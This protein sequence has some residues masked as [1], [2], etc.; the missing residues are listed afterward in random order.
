MHQ[1]KPKVPTF[2]HVPKN[3]GTYYISMMML[4]FR[5]WRR[6]YRKK[7]MEMQPTLEDGSKKESIKN[8]EMNKEIIRRFSVIE[9]EMIDSN[10]VLPP[11]NNTPIEKKPVKNLK[12][13]RPVKTR[14]NNKNVFDSKLKNRQDE[15]S[16][17]VNPQKP[18][19]IDF[20]P[21]TSLEVDVKQLVDIR[22]NPLCVILDLGCTRSMGSR[23]AIDAFIS[24][25][26]KIGMTFEWQRCW[27]RMSFANSQTAWLEWC[28]VVR[29]PTQPPVCTTIDV[30]E[31]GNIPILFSL[32]QM[33]KLGL[34][35]KCSP[36]EVSLTC[37]T[38]GFRDVVLPFSTS[39]HVLLDLSE[40]KGKLQLT[41]QNSIYTDKCFYNDNST[42]APTETHTDHESEYDSEW[43][44]E[45]YNM[46]CEHAFGDAFP[47]SPARVRLSSKT[48]VNQERNESPGN[49]FHFTLFL[50]KGCYIVYQ[51][52]LLK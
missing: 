5:K 21:P 25:G 4:F 38:L 10:L 39:R 35:I 8:I 41:K 31:E 36:D 3:A 20:V 18:K 26:E 33:M 44:A 11:K 27:T 40:I 14:K 30:H 28:V 2:Y 52:L 32:P 22:R 24:A 46:S 49:S 42:E 7:W 45:Y 17:L 16:K 34:H 50:L 15:F 6:E 51:M 12:L 19:E 43:Y 29:F 47:S 23:P 13:D 1:E 48:S 37:D 9:K